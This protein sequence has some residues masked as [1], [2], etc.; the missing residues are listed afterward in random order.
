PILLAIVL[1]LGLK[2]AARYVMPAILAVTAAIAFWYWQLSLAQVLASAVQG[3]FITFDI[4][5]IIFGAILLLTTLQYSG[6][7]PAIRAQFTGLSSDRRVQIIIIAWLFG[8]FMEGA[9]GFG[10]P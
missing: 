1:V 3:L 2:L 4:L 7:L 5:L 9:S 6:A 8:S 10:T